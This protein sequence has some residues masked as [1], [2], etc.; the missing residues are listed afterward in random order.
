MT[1]ELERLRRRY[2]D[3]EPG[4]LGA[5]RSY[6]VLCPLI[7]GEGGLRLLFEV[8]SSLVSQG[9]EVCFPGGRMESGETPQDCALRETEEELSIP[10]REVTLLGTPDFICNQRDFLLRPVL[11]LVSPAGLRSLRPSPAE[12]AEVFTVP[13]AFFRETAPDLRRYELVPQVPEDFPYGPVGI[14]RNYPWSHGRV[15]VPI[16]R[17]E[18]HVIWGMTARLV[19]EIIR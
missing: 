11:G 16:W 3:H 13:L 19:R 15:E 12:V 5:S 6:A 10:R 2:Q 14:P 18:G 9:G 7:E 17:Y 8:R 4:L 1:G